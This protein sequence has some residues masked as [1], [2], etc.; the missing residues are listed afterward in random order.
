[1]LKSGEEFYSKGGGR[2]ILFQGGGHEAGV[3]FQSLCTTQESKRAEKG[4][5]VGAKGGKDGRRKELRLVESPARGGGGE[6][7]K[8]GLCFREGGDKAKRGLTHSWSKGHEG[9][10]RKEWT[11]KLC[12]DLGEHHLGL[13]Q[14]NGWTKEALEKKKKKPAGEPT[15][16]ERLC[17]Y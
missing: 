1:M 17:T 8:E 12:H 7:A 2:E 11:W 6:D 14:G 13:L 4:K 3:L 9:R 16:Q 5:G 10:S 15:S